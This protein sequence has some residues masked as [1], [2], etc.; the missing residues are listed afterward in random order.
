MTRF[1]KEWWIKSF[2]NHVT[3]IE[4]TYLCIVCTIR[5]RSTDIHRCHLIR[6]VVWGADRPRLHCRTVSCDLMKIAHARFHNPMVTSQSVSRTTV[7]AGGSEPLQG[8]FHHHH[9]HHHHHHLFLNREGRWGTTDDFKTSFLHY[10][11]FSTS[12][13]HKR[14]EFSECLP[15]NSRSIV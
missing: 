5:P 4:N 2:P 10:F 13:N 8:D 11:L 7:P 12:I 3:Y 15:L 14:C 9:H 6:S 1:A